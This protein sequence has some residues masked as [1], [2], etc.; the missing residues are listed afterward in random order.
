MKYEAASLRTKQQLAE[1]L[2]KLM[3]TKPFNRITVTELVADCGLNR[4]TFYYHFEDIYDL[5]HWVLD[6]AAQDFR[7]YDLVSSPEQ[8]LSFVVDYVMDNRELLKS[9]YD[10]FGSVEMERA[11]LGGI[12]EFSAAALEQAEEHSS[13]RLPDG[14]REYFVEFL[15]EACCGMLLS[16]IS[17]GFPLDKRETIEYSNL[18]IGSTIRN[19]LAEHGEPIEG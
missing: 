13:R 11:F 4:K 9:V 1:S 18:I 10:S 16:H 15:A 6:Q 5:L 8:A 12:R 7:K 19:L 3:R 2:K 14:L 17:G